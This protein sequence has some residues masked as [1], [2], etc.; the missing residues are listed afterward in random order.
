MNS[1]ITGKNYNPEIEGT[2]VI[3]ILKQEE[4]KKTRTQILML[5]TTFNMEHTFYWKAV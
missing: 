1:T 4:N 3:P 2:L 5:K